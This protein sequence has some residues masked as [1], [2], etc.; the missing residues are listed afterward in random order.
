M[1]DT[2]VLG[3]VCHPRKG[4]EVKLWL[5]GALGVRGHAVLIPEEADFELRRELIR[6]GSK[7][8]AQ[9]DALPARATYVPIDTATMRLAA[10]LWARLWATGQ[11]LG[12]ADALGA[13][14]ILAAQA[15]LQG[16]VV[17]TDNARHL[18][19]MVETRR[20]GEV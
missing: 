1:L 7:A 19:R 6:L 12:P 4:A 20:W 5:N 11:P 16:A 3:L 10:A 9:L 8:L 13:D 14:A 17:V 18:G 2:G 15:I